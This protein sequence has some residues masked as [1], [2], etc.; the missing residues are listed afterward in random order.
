MSRYLAFLAVAVV[1][2]ISF[3]G[4]Q[5]KKSKDTPVYVFD[6]M[7][8]QNKYKAQGENTLF[9][10]GRDARP[11]VA[12]TV[13]RGNGLE[14]TKVFSDDFRRAESQNPSFVSG[15]DAKGAFLVGFPEKSL[16]FSKGQLNDYKVSQLTLEAGRGKFQIYCAVC[17]GQAGDGNGI[18]KV[19]SA[20]EGDAAIVTIASLQTP[21]I[22]AYPNG[23]I[24]DVITNGKNTMMGYGDK[25]SPEERWAVVAYVRALQ[26]SQ[27]C[28]P[29][30]VPAA[31]KAQIK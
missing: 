17:H 5:G 22:R 9:A 13:A 24:Y 30:L 11:P 25:L 31:V 4:F 2:T 18:M 6:D 29:E 21:I 27:N 28:P 15:K 23:Q 14:P 3:L 10:D 1:A 16:S 7:D 8:Y 20:L 19:R 26:L 12:G